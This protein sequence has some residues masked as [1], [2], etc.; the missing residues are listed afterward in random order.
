MRKIAIIGASYLQ[1]P[2]V[3]K[4]K[5]MGIETHCFA[6]AKGA[7]CKDVCDYFYDISTLEKEKILI[8]CQDIKID[9]IMTIASDIA[10]PTV[11]YVAE[12]MNLIG[13]RFS[14]SE[15]TTDKFLM[16]NAFINYGIRSPKYQLIKSR[17]ELKNL[18]NLKFPLIVKPTDRSGSRGV[19]KVN[20]KSQLEDAIEFALAESFSGQAIV[21]EFIEGFE[22]SVES[23]SWKGVHYV[24]AITDKI[25]SGEPDF[26]ELQH[27]QPSTLEKEV[28]EKIKECTLKALVS[29]SHQYGASHSEFKIDNNG[30]VYI[31]EVGARMG[32]DFIGSDLVFLST[33]YDY[34]E[35]C[36]NVSLNEFKEPKLKNAGHAGVYFLCEEYAWLEKIIINNQEEYIYK[37]EIQIDEIKTAHC[38]ADRS[39]YLIYKSNQKIIL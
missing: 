38:S 13:N 10:V 39:G 8:V 3:Q 27:H 20:N 1:L 35:A 2:L 22:V 4:C 14:D 31:I 15:I 25:T 18:K 24:L 11:C 9:G 29:L 7:V 32:G 6:W 23:I 19:Q 37:A 16:R 34:L 30:D 21:E 5:E 36:I 28:Q 12:K 33:A 17:L 26:V